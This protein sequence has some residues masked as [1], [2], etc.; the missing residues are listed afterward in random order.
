MPV[1]H[2]LTPL[3]AGGPPNGYGSMTQAMNV[4]NLDSQSTDF[5]FRFVDVAK[6]FPPREGSEPFLAVDGINLE[7][8]QGRFVCIVGPS[9]CGKS[10][11]LNMAAGLYRPTR[12]TVRFRGEPLQRVNTSVGYMTQHDN[13]LPWRTLLQNVGIA[14]EI[15]HVPRREREERVHDLLEKL[16]LSGFGDRYPS[17]LSGGM[18]KRA[19][20]ARTLIY[21]PA[22]LLMDEPFGAVDAMMRLTLQREL[23]ELWEREKKT[24]LFV[25]HD[26]EEAISLAD[27]IVVFGTKPGRIIHREVVQLGRPRDPVE[28]RGTET[29]VETW[30]RLWNLVEHHASGTP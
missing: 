4:T 17:E 24:V 9:G 21:E 27:E 18:R 13:L 8:P 19:T 15:R 28:V 2:P 10:T 5:E 30:D 14:L 7:I 23:L 20:L 26:L 16:G 3:S 22:T 11:L 1:R 12:G 29:F 6:E 25:T